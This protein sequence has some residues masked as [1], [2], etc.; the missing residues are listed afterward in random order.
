MIRSEYCVVHI[1]CAFTSELSLL[2]GLGCYLIPVHSAFHPLHKVGIYGLETLS[3]PN[4]SNAIQRSTMRGASQ[5]L[6]FVDTGTWIA[7]NEQSLVT[8]SPTSLPPP[9]PRLHLLQTCPQQ[10]RLPRHPH[11]HPRGWGPRFPPWH[12]LPPPLRPLHPRHPSSPSW[13]H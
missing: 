2:A 8:R 5:P 4:A 6:L 9:S 3:G 13:S 7:Q 12:R 1:V 11:R 10:C